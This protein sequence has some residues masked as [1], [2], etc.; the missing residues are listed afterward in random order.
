MICRVFERRHLSA[1]VG[2]RWLGGRGGEGKGLCRHLLRRCGAELGC[3]RAR[4][5]LQLKKKEKNVGS[6]SIRSVMNGT[7]VAVSGRMRRL[8]VK[9]SEEHR[10]VSP[11]GW[12]GAEVAVEEQEEEI[13]C[14]SI[15]HNLNCIKICW[16]YFPIGFSVCLSVCARARVCVCVCVSVSGSLN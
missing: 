10:R 14:L 16:G 1:G 15:G 2:I 7:K 11:G 12:G 5:R 3:Q 9:T 8:N 4:L 13:S 6:G